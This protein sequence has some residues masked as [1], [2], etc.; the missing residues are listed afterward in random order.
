MKALYDTRTKKH[1][2][3]NT[4]KEAEIFIEKYE[5]PNYL[6]SVNVYYFDGGGYNGKFS[7]IAYSIR[8]NANYTQIFIEKIQEKLTN[9][10]A[11]YLACLKCVEGAEDNSVI[12]GDSKLIINQ[13]VGSY[14]CNIERLRLQRD[15]IRVHTKHKN[16]F[17]MWVR[18]SDNIAGIM[19]E[20]D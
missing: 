1:F 18:R 5:N 8:D 17:F 16:L 14:K 19:L 6:L 9:N 3:F 4:N 11:E 15:I 7:K 2:I 13:I 10:D 20:N 12:I